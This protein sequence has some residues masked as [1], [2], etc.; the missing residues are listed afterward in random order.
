MI[1]IE[2]LD[3]AVFR[4]TVTGLNWSYEVDGLRGTVVRTENAPVLH[5]PA[6]FTV[7]TVIEA[8]M[9]KI[10]DTQEPHEDPGTYPDPPEDGE[11][12]PYCPTCHIEVDLDDSQCP[13]CGGGLLG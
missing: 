12:V 7:G 3:T 6:Q 1:A 10:A 4:C 8:I 13:E 9:N 5:L 2:E 11:T